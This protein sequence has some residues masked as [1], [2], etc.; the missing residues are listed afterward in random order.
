MT[1]SAYDSFAELPAHDW[2][3]LTA[4][5]N[6][7]S[8]SGFAGVREEALPPG[9]H[10]RYLLARDGDGTPL[11]KLEVYSFADVPHDLYDPG[12]LLGEVISD[13]RAAHLNARPIS[14]A[15]GWSEF[16]GQMPGHVNASAEQRES[17]LGRLATEA[18]RLAG[19]AG[20]SVLAYCYLPLETARE[21]VKAHA[22]DGAVLLLHN[23]ET[24]IPIGL[25]ADFDDYVAWLPAGRRQRVR[26][27]L[28]RFRESGR[29]VTELPL[30]EV[31]KEIAPLNRALMQKYGHAAY[32]EERAAA[33]FDRQSRFLGDESSVLLSKDNDKTVGFL[34]RYRHHDMLYARAA[35]FDYSVPNADDYYNLMFYHQ[36]AAGVG[37]SV[38]SIHLGINTFEAK[39]RRGAQPTPLYSVFVGVDRPLEAQDSVVREYNRT[40]AAAFVTKHDKYVV[41]GID[42]EDWL[43]D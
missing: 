43:L 27:E 15:A 12:D 13:E 16:R 21:L 41:G 25:W 24:S 3:T 5:A 7:Y 30:P 22:S 37:R 18:L 26:R 20:S 6:I 11:A 9:A 23:I 2:D 42:T 14:V 40:R 33:V 34:L 36:I 1:V 39:M 4:G 10:V 32:D 17:A 19:Q 8:T 31:V 29:V 35:G 28:R 38:R